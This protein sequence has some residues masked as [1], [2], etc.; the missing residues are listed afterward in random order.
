MKYLRWHSLEDWI[1]IPL[2]SLMAG[3]IVPWLGLSPI[4]V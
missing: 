1:A 4:N 2:V 3:F